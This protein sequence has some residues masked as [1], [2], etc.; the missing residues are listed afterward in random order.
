MSDTSSHNLGSVEKKPE[1]DNKAVAP[2]PPAAADDIP[3]GGTVAWL[4]VLGGFFVIFNT[5]GIFNSYG[6][7][8]GYYLDN[9]LKGESASNIS[10]IGSFQGFLLLMV[11]AFTGPIFDMGYFRSLLIAGSFMV[12]F[13]MMMTSIATK[14]WEVSR[15]LLLSDMKLMILVLV[16]TRTRHCHWYW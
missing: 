11:G 15:R 14:Y 8:Q 16:D 7:F 13:G 4:Q 12:V 3:D 5:W 1:E 6:A 10:W 9:L 2:P